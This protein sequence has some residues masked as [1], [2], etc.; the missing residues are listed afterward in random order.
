MNRNDLVNRLVNR[1]IVSKGAGRAI[2]TCLIYCRTGRG[3]PAS[4]PSAA[5]ADLANVKK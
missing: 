3:R 4:P 5:A 2:C 1:K